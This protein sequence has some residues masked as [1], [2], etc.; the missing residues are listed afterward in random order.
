M[1]GF[2]GNCGA[3]LSDD[4]KFCEVC[5]TKVPQPESDICSKCGTK[6][7]P[8]VK[9]CPAC[10][11]PTGG[12]QQSAP[13]YTPQQSAPAPAY[14]PQS[15]AS[16]AN[17]QRQNAQSSGGGFIV[18][19]SPSAQRAKGKSNGGCT[20]CGCG[21]LIIIIMLL[22]GG[23]LLGGLYAVYLKNGGQSINSMIEAQ[24]VTS[25]DFD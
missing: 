9:F 10:G 20:G 5:G 1:A 13:A 8:G 14:V 12:A 21:C 18:P 6:L 7:Q 25:A 3:K 23:A 24:N 17:V 19:D 15:A 4:A 16:Q 11:A 2:C 22:L